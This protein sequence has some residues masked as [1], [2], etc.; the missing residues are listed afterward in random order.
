MTATA[1]SLYDTLGGETGL[2]E[3]VRKLYA[4]LLDDPTTKDYFDGV[5]MDRQADRLAA[6]LSGPLGGPNVYDGPSLRATHAGMGVTD[7]A[8]DSTSTHLVAILHERGIPADA[9]DELGT[10]V[11]SL[12]PE[13]VSA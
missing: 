6:W 8:F 12:R 9:I 11:T 2:G 7:V 13:V 3:I 1:P 4:R 5:D 10:A